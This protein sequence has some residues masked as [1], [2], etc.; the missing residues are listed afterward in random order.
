M[1]EIKPIVRLSW[2]RFLATEAGMAGMLYLRESTPGIL[3]GLPHEVQFDAGYTQG[4]LKALDRIS[5]VIAAEPE[6]EQNPSND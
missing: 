1:T 3:K 5:E 4:Y 2:R 6:K